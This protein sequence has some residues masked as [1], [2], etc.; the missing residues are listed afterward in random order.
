MGEGE[1]QCE[2]SIGDHIQEVSSHQAV[3]PGIKI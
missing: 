3:F 1:K 2:N